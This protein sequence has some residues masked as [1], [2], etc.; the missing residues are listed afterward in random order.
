MHNTT[1][2][3]LWNVSKFITFKLSYGLCQR[4]LLS[5]YLSIIC[6]ERL[7]VV[8]KNVVC[9]GSSKPIFI[10]NNGLYM[11]HLIMLTMFLCSLRVKETQIKD[12]VT[13]FDRFSCVLRLKINIV[14]WWVFYFSFIPQ[15]KMNQFT[16]INVIMSTTS[17]DK[18]LGFPILKGRV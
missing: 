1:S 11:L 9:S 8:V 5:P 6:N 14:K 3:I 16:I 15:A 18:C 2:S 4:N 13:F 7:S 17:L 12:M 10:S